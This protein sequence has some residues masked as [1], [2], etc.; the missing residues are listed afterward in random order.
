MES[1]KQEDYS[2]KYYEL[3]S[4]FVSKP[5]DHSKLYLEALVNSKIKELSKESE[6]NFEKSLQ[7]FIL[8]LSLYFIKDNSFVVEN[9]FSLIDNSIYKNFYDFLNNPTKSQ[10]EKF[11]KS[12][13]E[14]NYGATTIFLICSKLCEEEMFGQ[15]PFDLFFII[16][17]KKNRSRLQKILG[18]DFPLDENH[19]KIIQRLACFTKI[20]NKIEIRTIDL[21][22]LFKKQDEENMKKNAITKIDNN[23]E[24]FQINQNI[25]KLSDK[26]IE[27]L[28]K[29]NKS[30]EI[31]NIHGQKKKNKKTKNAELNISKI[32]VEETAIEDKKDN[33]ISEQSKNVINLNL[34]EESLKEK[35]KFYNYLVKMK[36]KYRQ[37]Q[38]ETPVLD[39]L[40]RNKKKL[41]VN[42]FKYTKNEDVIIDH[43]YNNLVAFIINTNLNI[44]DFGDEKYGYLCYYYK[45][46]DKKIY[47]ESIFSLV[48]LSLLSDRISSELNFP[49]DKFKNPDKKQAHIVFKSRS[50]SF[51]YFIN[52]N[53][54][55]KKFNLKEKARVIYSFKSIEDLESVNNNVI[56][57][58]NKVIE[59]GL[60][61]LDGIVFVEN[62]ISLDLEK[63]CFMI[64][65]PFKFGIFLGTDKQ[66]SIQ[67][68]D[69]DTNKINNNIIPSNVEL[70][71]NTLALIE[72]KDQF[73]PYEEGNENENKPQNFYNMVKNLIRKVKIFKQIFEIEKRN[74][75][76]I[77]ILLFYDVIQKENYY[78]DLKEAVYDSFIK[79]DD[80][81]FDFEFQCVYIKASYLT[82]GLI[83]TNDR[84]E[85][86][87]DKLENVNRKLNA[88]I[89]FIYSL[90]LPKEK[91]NDLSKII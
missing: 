40:I 84:L 73:P 14:L 64:D 43:L 62:K 11:L 10:Y 54:L 81:L 34:K 28:K 4:K 1:S 47:V 60:E 88:L 45:D 83:N 13:F 55:I 30:P 19:D 17:I 22:N 23:N 53:I 76:N 78:D 80:E 44:I 77:K 50:L 91:L 26:E 90:N 35:N 27:E 61:E 29:E 18:E 48:D 85:N 57:I 65:N 32:N 66:Y 67:G 12:F 70:K 7:K 86:L 41:E 58:K 87:N 42:F 39:Y 89:D 6:T 72:I 5:N 74:I 37:L 38:Y 71:K 20:R 8:E 59:K 3:L 68:Y 36:E 79:N 9:Y 33:K 82:G 75:E 52:S 16:I 25:N 21:L 24:S 49:K 51:E 2:Y 46:N 31:K 63:N 56:K 69:L 15:I